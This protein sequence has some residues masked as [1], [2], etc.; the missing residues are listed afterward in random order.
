V[1]AGD[2]ASGA[3]SPPVACVGGEECLQQKQNCQQNGNCSAQA[4][5]LGLKTT[6]T[7][8]YIEEDADEQ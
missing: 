1:G 7:Y 5:A 3:I 2:N 4:G 8:L 6:R